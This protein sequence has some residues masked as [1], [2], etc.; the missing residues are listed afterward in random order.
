MSQ[1]DQ[2][3]NSHGIHR[4]FSEL[5]KTL[6]EIS[7]SVVPYDHVAY[8]ARTNKLTKSIQHLIHTE[9]PDLTSESLL[10]SINGKL[11]KALNFINSYKDQDSQSKDIYCLKNASE[12]VDE[13]CLLTAPLTLAS[14]PINSEAHLSSLNTYKL[15]A[16][17]LLTTRSD[18]VEKFD[19]FY[20]KLLKIQKIHRLTT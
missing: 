5:Q 11:E 10:D 12:H 20:K 9:D 16:E 19:D 3:F 6:K 13:A 8:L 17:K 15:Q 7:K 2:D 1:H 4:T 14:Y 18:Q